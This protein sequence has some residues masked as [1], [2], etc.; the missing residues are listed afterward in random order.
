MIVISD[1]SP[2]TNLLKINRLSLLQSVFERII[3]PEKVLAEIQDWKELGVDINSITQADWI[4][5]RVCTDLE[6]VRMLGEELDAG[7]AEAIVLS[8]ELKADYLLIDERKG[9]KIAKRQGINA[10]GLVGVLLK[11]KSQGSIP[12][13]IPLIEELREKAGFWISDAFFEQ[14]KVIVKEQ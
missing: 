1:T 3:I 9:W 8:H 12:F 11:A 7:E 4:E 14:I 5:V 10:V 6:R 13:V 2:L